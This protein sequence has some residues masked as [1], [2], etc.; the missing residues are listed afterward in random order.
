MSAP[1]N[2]GSD[3]TLSPPAHLPSRALGMAQASSKGQQTVTF[4]LLNRV[5]IEK[6]CPAHPVPGYLPIEELHQCFQPGARTRPLLA[7][8]PGQ[9]PRPK[10]HCRGAPADETLGPRNRGQKPVS[11]CT[12]VS[13]VLCPSWQNSLSAGPGQ[14]ELRYTPSRA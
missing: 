2:R 11:S 8:V 14:L 10:A 12:V 6:S 7:E 3:R 4:Q 1:G 9:R 13:W 5:I